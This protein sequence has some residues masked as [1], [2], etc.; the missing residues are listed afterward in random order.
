MSVYFINSKKFDTA[1]AKNLYNNGMFSSRGTDYY[2]TKSG[3][4][5]RVNWTQ[6]QGEHTYAE[7]ISKEDFIAE[8]M[9]SEHPVRAMIALANAGIN[10]DQEI[11]AL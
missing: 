2:Q 11:E 7:T 3:V 1:T 5:V 4:F 6:W 10:I 8:M 9:N